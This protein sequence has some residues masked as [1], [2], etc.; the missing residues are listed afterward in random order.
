MG[1]HGRPTR[2][3]ATGKFDGVQLVGA[4][5]I[6]A[7]QGGNPLVQLGA[8]LVGGFFAAANHR[9]R[10]DAGFRMISD[11]LD[12]TYNGI[13]GWPGQ[14]VQIPT[15]AGTATEIALPAPTTPVS[16][17]DELISAVL[18]FAISAFVNVEPTWDSRWCTSTGSG[19]G[20]H[21]V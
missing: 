3:R 17:F 18:N 6:D 10:A 19:L 7:V 14:T 4:S 9:R 2:C 15:N 11:M 13:Y 8:Y 1:S 5:H 16:P 12:G 20:L 21:S